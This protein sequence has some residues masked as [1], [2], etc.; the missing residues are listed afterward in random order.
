M[1]RVQTRN[2]NDVF[3]KKWLM[4]HLVYVDD[5]IEILVELAHTSLCI[6]F[7][8][9]LRFSLDGEYTRYLW[10]CWCLATSCVCRYNCIIYPCSCMISP[11]LIYLV[12]LQSMQLTHRTKHATRQYFGRARTRSA[13]CMFAF[14]PF[15]TCEYLR[16]CVCSARNTEGQ[17]VI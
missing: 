14:Y 3:P 11:D 16:V 8:E 17:I 5:S 1:N 13:K 7:S 2:H 15:C 4:L 6:R 12:A 10:Y 9:R